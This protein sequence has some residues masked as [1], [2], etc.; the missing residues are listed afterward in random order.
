M[1]FNL[2][3][4]AIDQVRQRIDEP[5]AA[6]ISNRFIT[7]LLN[8]GAQNVAKE[9]YMIIDFFTYSTVANQQEYDLPSDFIRSVNVIYEPGASHRTLK[10]TQLEYLLYPLPTLGDMPEEYAI[11][12][13]NRKMFL[14]P[15]PA[16]N[17]ASTTL[18]GALNATATTITVA[19]TSQFPAEGG[20]FLVDSEIIQYNS[21][22]PTT[23]VGC[24]RGAD[25]TVATTHLTAATARW[26]N[27]AQLYARNPSM[28][29]RNYTT[30]TIAFTNGSPT[31][32]GTGTNW[33]SGQ[34]VYPGDYLGVGSFAATGGAETFPLRWYKILSVGGTG[35]ITL[36]EPFAEPSS[37]AEAYI[38][39]DPSELYETE[40]IIPI[41]FAVYQCSLKTGNTNKIAGAKADYEAELN[42]AISRKIGP[43]YL[44]VSKKAPELFEA[45]RKYLRMPAHYPSLG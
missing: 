26:R 45:V 5:I 32:T 8:L 24:T 10:E 16:A 23:F 3:A 43:D 1:Y 22:T 29:Y 30:G 11:D 31:V 13:A 34:N 28:L 4:V 19:D 2:H 44:P 33:L 41:L 12:L 14:R 9:V 17:A 27:L 37:T 18:N 35:T 36:T 40:S 15:T 6:A 20:R 21:T 25:G 42:A 38:I 7:S 39:T